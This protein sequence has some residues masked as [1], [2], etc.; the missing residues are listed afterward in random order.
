MKVLSLT[1]QKPHSTGSGFYLTELVKGLAELGHKQ[2]VI[3]G[4]YKSDTVEFPKGIEF[5]P[6]YFKIKQLPFSIPGMSDEMPYESTVYGEMTA[7]MVEQ[8]LLAFEE[9]VKR[10][11][12]IFQPEV[13]IC[14]HL[15]ILTAKVRQWC[16]N[17]KIIGVCHGTDIRQ[18]KKIPLC[19]EFV[20]AQIQKL[21][22]VLALQENQEVEISTVYKIP[23]DKMAVIGVGYNHHVFYRQKHE[24]PRVPIRIAFAGKIA[25]KKGVHC[26]IRAVSCL[27]Y[28][29][30]EVILS[31][32]GGYGNKKEYE[33]I[34]ALAKQCPFQVEFLGMLTQVELAD[35]LNQS[36]LFVLPSFYEGLPLVLLEAKACGTKVICTDLPGVKAWL[37]QNLENHGISFL[38]P[39]IMKNTDE[40]EECSLKDFEER[41]GCTIAGKIQ[42]PFT[43]CEHI[44]RLSWSGICEK[45]NTI[46]ENINK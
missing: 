14:H 20:G 18:M 41:L 9:T 43:Q 4:I 6:V 28:K 17:L 45:L 44:E 10:T 26:L 38:E 13:I 5:C 15:Y 35:L 8:F 46:I 40:A 29:Q 12:D 22:F 31:L 11:V 42:E 30:D 19:R 33:G 1:A 7:E 32:A 27:N 23:R 37:D 25:E 24:K 34:A 2:F 16:P 36:H 3:G 39:P 21:D